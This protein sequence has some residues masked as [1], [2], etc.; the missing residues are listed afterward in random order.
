[1]TA[2]AFDDRELLTLRDDLLCG[3]HQGPES[4]RPVDL[5]RELLFL[6]A[7]VRMLRAVADA[8]A[9]ALA[10]SIPP[11]VIQVAPEALDPSQKGRLCP[12]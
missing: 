11:V 4:W 8:Y 12:P 1:M 6:R 3:D 2:D 7:E 9:R 10:T 5:V